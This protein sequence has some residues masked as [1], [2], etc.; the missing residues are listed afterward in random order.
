MSNDTGLSTLQFG[1]LSAIAVICMILAVVNSITFNANAE[2]RAKFSQGQQFIAQTAKLRQVG[3][4]L[5]KTTAQVAIQKQ[6]QPLL[7]LLGRFGFT[8]KENSAKGSE[9][10]VNE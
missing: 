5:V 1:L 8:V 4:E 7:D 3:G 2:Q 10:Q 6:D 9:E